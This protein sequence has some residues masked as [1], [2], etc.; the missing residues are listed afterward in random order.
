MA[1]CVSYLSL[2]ILSLFI[3]YFAP[4]QSTGGFSAQLIHRDSPRSPFHNS[5]ETHSQ[6][7]TNAFRRSINRLSH[8]NT[9][10][11]E[12]Q[13]DVFPDGDIG[14]Y[15]MNISIGT[16]PVEI[17]GIADTGSDLIWTQCKPCAHCYKQDAP[18]FDPKSSSTYEPLSCLSTECKTLNATMNGTFCATKAG[19]STC[20]YTYTYGNG[21]GFTKGDIATETVTLTSV[22][23]EPIAFPKTIIGCGR[24]NSAG[25]F[26]KREFGIIGLGGGVI[27]LVSQLG[28]SIDGKFSYCLVPMSD[29]HYFLSKIYFGANAIVSGYGVVTTPLV[30]KNPDTF[31]LLTL[32]AI[33]VDDLIIEFKGSVFGTTEGNIIIDSGTTM[34]MLPKYFY[35]ELESAIAS[36]IQAKRVHEP[37]MVSG[38]CYKFNSNFKVPKIVVR[39]AFASVK[40]DPLNTF[41]M[42]SKDVGCFTFLPTD[43]GIAIYGNLNQMNF[44]IGYDTMKRT[45]SF[46]PTDCTIH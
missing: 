11:H 24:N 30:K 13:S 15:I 26:D 43:D 6:R 41:I 32:Q 39:F 34:T 5:S 12:L 29:V 16:P 19:D 38:L 27:S 4:V 18:L 28:P 25:F 33:S 14:E 37:D 17:L 22:S 2:L 3:V 10:R 9:S 45:V 46:K 35:L 8:F 31:Y 36:K 44:L 23:G 40:L 20:L 7:L 42:R 21:S 1:A